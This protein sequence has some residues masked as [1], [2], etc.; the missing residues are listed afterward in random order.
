[1]RLYERGLIYRGTSRHPLVP[2]LPHVALR[3]RGGAPGD[4]GRAVSHR[5]SGR[6]RSE[7]RSHHRRHDASRDDAR[8]RR[9]RREPERRALSRLDRQAR[10]AADPRH[11]D[12][13]RRRRLRRSGVRHRR[14]EDHAGARRE[15]LRG[16]TP[17]RAA[18]AR[19]DRRA[20]RACARWP[21]PTAACPRSF[22]GSTG[23]RRASSIVEMLRGA[24]ARS[25][26]RR[27]TST[28]CGT[29]TAATRSSSRGCRDQWFVQ[30][31]A[32]RRAGARRRCATGRDA[33]PAREVGR[34]CTSTG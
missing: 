17:S 30:H 4:D 26:R 28:P 9:R 24:R 6:R 32:A 31:G 15:R 23:S 29:A 19:R 2:A 8:R 11:P 25:R 27:C 34:R 12:P 33:H 14:R 22:A 18:D 7:R 3:R 5:V 20:R 13:D 21:T 16:R 10:P 1:M